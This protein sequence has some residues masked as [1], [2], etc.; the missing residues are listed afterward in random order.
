MVALLGAWAVLGPAE[1]GAPAPVAAELGAAWDDY[2]STY[3]RCTGRVF[4]PRL[5]G[6]ST[7]EGQAYGL[8]RAAWLGDHRQFRRMLRWTRRHLQG[9]DPAA[10]PAWRWQPR[11]GVLDPMPAADADQLMAYAL[12]VGAEA[13]DEPAYRAQALELLGQL[14]QREVAPL[15]D[16]LVMVPGPWALGADPLRL[17]PSYFLPFALRAFAAADP[18]HPWGR[19]LDDSYALLL[20]AGL[21]EALAPDWLYVDP[22]TGSRLPAPDPAH[23]RHGFEAFR[24]AWALAADEAWSGDPRATALLAPSR[25]LA[26]RLAAD[27]G[28]SGVM[29]ADGSPLE[30]WPYIGVYATLVAAWAGPLPAEAEALYGAHI[31]PRRAR[32]GWA[33]ADDYYGQNWTWLG[34]ALWTGIARPPEK[35]R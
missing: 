10:L 18:A 17:N 9:G 12:L 13:F 20:E 7:S 24:L 22:R 6:G 26:A 31:A 16:R 32:H 11:R 15:G 14:W 25:R 27:G 19:L 3:V 5:D 1:A 34:L 28:L 30:P 8:L 21:G 35:I 33:E 4:D 2:V 29:A 23:E